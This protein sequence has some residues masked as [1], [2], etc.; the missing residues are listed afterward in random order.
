VLI[1]C[2]T[3]PCGAPYKSKP[4][5][6]LACTYYNTVRMRYLRLGPVCVCVFSS[7]CVALGSPT[8]RSGTGALGLAEPHRRPL[9]KEARRLAG[10]ATESM[11]PSQLIITPTH[12]CLI[13]LAAP[14]ICHNWILVSG[15]EELNNQIAVCLYLFIY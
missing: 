2:Y 11:W 12:S 14:G 15:M 3:A 13:V 5:S 1:V 9:S 6:E 10:A 4:S 8:V 7:C